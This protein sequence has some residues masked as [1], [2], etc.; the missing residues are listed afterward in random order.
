MGLISLDTK[1]WKQ[2]RQQLLN[3]FLSGN[4]ALCERPSATPLCPNCQRQ[5]Q[6]SQLPHS[7]YQAQAGLPVVSWGAYDGSL[8]QCIASLKYSHRQDV[9]QLLGTELAKTWLNLVPSLAPRG[10]REVVIV[11]IPL[12]ESKLKQRGFNQAETLARWFCRMTHLPLHKQLLKRID[13][14]QAQHSLNRKERFKNLSQ[15]FDVDRHQRSRLAQPTV[16]LVDDIFT[17]GAT[18]LN[19]AR[20]LRRHGVS[21]AGIC[22]V[23]RT[24]SAAEHQ[25][26][27]T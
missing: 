24:L 25:S 17:T 15:A 26:C 13:A 7:L 14:T 20:V 22:T 27:N 19:C 1:T 9:A 4:C 16:W 6:Q 18:A 5:V 10:S 2:G 3:V 23:A 11:P 12:H 8:K 21:V